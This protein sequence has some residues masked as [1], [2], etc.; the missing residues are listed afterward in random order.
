MYHA[1]CDNQ[2]FD[3]LMEGFAEYYNYNEILQLDDS[4]H[5]CDAHH[6]N[7]SGVDIFNNSLIEKI[8]DQ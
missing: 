2:G 1:Y 3:K 5:F 7:Q 4:L 8:K 6:L